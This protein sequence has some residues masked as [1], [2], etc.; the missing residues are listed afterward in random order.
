[1]S[2]LHSSLFFEINWGH[3]KDTV[4]DLHSSLFFEIN[5]GH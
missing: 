2:D 3:Y 5:W 4:S 1:V